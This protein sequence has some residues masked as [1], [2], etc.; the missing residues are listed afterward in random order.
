MRFGKPLLALPAIAA[1]VLVPWTVGLATQLPHQAVAYHWNTAWAGL[2]ITI[3]IGLALTSGL[4][5]RRDPRAALTATATI[6][7]MCTDS[8][9]D[10]CTSAPGHPFVYAAAEATAELI[11][12]AACLTIGLRTRRT[13][14]PR[15]PRDLPGSDEQRP[16]PLVAPGQGPGPGV[17]S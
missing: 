2:D 11:V 17:L 5:H 6:T 14:H 1:I 9:F 16:V 4:S 7:L 3:A 12:A 15:M 13:T 8:W 10:L